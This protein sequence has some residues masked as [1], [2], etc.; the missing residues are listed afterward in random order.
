MSIPREGRIV[1][2]DWGEVRLGLA[3]S[4]ERQFLASPLGALVR[5]PGKRFPMPAF[6]SHLAAASPVGIVVGH[7]LDLSG[8]E[9]ESAFAAR[10]LAEVLA[11]RTR[12]PVELVDE[13]LTTVRAHRAIRDQQG[14]TRGR[15]ED[16]DAL[17]AS[18][19]LQGFLDMRRG[20]ST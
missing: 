16:V 9:G 4:D 17:A 11:L 15:R 8:A 13:R 18:I 14:S 19:L 12:L 5:R 10:E 7:P 3:L 2:V 6:L 1:A 20:S